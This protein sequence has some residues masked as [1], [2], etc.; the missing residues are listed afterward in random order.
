MGLLTSTESRIGPQIEALHG[1]LCEDHPGIARMAI[2]LYDPGT[3]QLRTFAHSTLGESPLRHYESFLEDVPSLRRLAARGGVRILNDL[4][5]AVNPSAEHS[6]RL[7]AKGYR[8]SLT[9]PFHEAGAL[10]GFLFYDA[11]EPGFF[12]EALAHRLEV[13]SRLAILM[14]ME[15]L[16][17]PRVLKAAVR[18]AGH[19]GRVRDKE[20]GAHISR[21]SRYAK[22]IACGLAEDFGLSDEWI[23]F[24]CLFTPLHDIGKIGIP[25]HILLKAGPLDPGELAIMRTH[26][27]KGAELVDALAREFGLEKLPQFEILRNIVR[28]HHEQ[29]DGRGYPAG[30]HGEEIPLEARIVTVADVFDGLLSIRPYKP[31]WSDEQVLEFLQSRAGTHFDAAC[32]ASLM[33][34]WTRI[35]LIRDRFATDGPEDLTHEAYLPEL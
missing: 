8:A 12:T 18:M 7:L 35:R 24:V 9:V 25:D 3:D 26:V 1:V 23:E 34:Q 27:E 16:A 33:T 28:C 32:V 17:T 31:A 19:I 13:Y 2:A 20:T 14:V 22:A 4:P 5:G 29:V 11:C 21:V 30:L 6:Q 15:S 10:R